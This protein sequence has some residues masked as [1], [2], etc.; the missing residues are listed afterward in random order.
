[1]HCKKQEHKKNKLW[2]SS[3][4][5]MA[6]IFFGITPCNLLKNKQNKGACVQALPRS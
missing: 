1:M 5:I 4:K 6:K 2:L 3:A